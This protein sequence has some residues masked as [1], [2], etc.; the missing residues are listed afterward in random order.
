MKINNDYD[1]TS[2]FQAK[3]DDPYEVKSVNNGE[4]FE[5]TTTSGDTVTISKEALELYSQKMAE[6]DASSI[7]ELS[8]DQKNELKQAM[9]EAGVTVTGSREAVSGAGGTSPESGDGTSPDNG[10]GEEAGAAGEASG[11]GS[12]G[13]DKIDKLEEAIKELEQEIQSLTAKAK[14]DETAA[15]EL[16]TKRM[17]L[18]SL[19][20]KLA[21][22]QQG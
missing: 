16:D 10:S 5:H 1:Y 20:A 19:K 12:G 6:Y 9:T 18:L 7:D 13:S 22:L 21:M 17:E 14:T 8:D 4:A 15:E 11:G 2:G 3:V